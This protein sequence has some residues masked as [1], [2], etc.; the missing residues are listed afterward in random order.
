MSSQPSAAQL[1]CH[2]CSIRLKKAWFLSAAS[3]DSPDAETAKAAGSSNEALAAPAATV[4]EDDESGGAAPRAAARAAALA[5]IVDLAVAAAAAQR[6]AL[7]AASVAVRSSSNAISFNLASSSSASSRISSLLLDSQSSEVLKASDKSPLAP[8]K[9]LRNSTRARPRHSSILATSAARGRASEVPSASA[10]ADSVSAQRSSNASTSQRSRA[11]A[12]SSG[13]G[14]AKPADRARYINFDHILATLSNSP[15]RCSSAA[16]FRPSLMPK[17]V[18]M[19]DTSGHGS[20]SLPAATTCE[21]ALTPPASG[22]REEDE[23][24]TPPPPSAPPASPVRTSEF[25]AS[26][27]SAPVLFSA[28]FSRTCFI[29]ARNAAR[30]SSP[31]PM[32][33]PSF[34]SMAPWRLLQGSESQ[35][36]KARLSTE[37]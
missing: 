10:H 30:L 25:E 16:L 9:S 5:A 33:P 23:E 28:L 31:P 13:A 2:S 27:G 36:G 17:L 19:R 34:R 3:T 8:T 20:A 11:S 1:D 14:S 22:L 26:P 37:A 7:A 4:D 12:A 35:D 6:T 32:T 21:I 24:A 15:R 29:L 18:A